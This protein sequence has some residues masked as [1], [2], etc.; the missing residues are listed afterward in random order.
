MQE[1][2]WKYEYKKESHVQYKNSQDELLDKKESLKWKMHWMGLIVDYILQ[3][4]S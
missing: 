1:D 2:R 4:K 3:R